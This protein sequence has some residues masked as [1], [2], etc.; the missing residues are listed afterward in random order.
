MKH[1][2]WWVTI[3][4]ILVLA[5]VCFALEAEC[6]G[7]GPLDGFPEGEATGVSEDGTVVVGHYSTEGFYWTPEDGMT[8]M[9]R[10]WPLATS[11]DGSVIVGATRDWEGF[12]WTENSDLV[13]IGDLPG[14]GFYSIARDVSDDGSVIVGE[15]KSSG[16]FQ[17]FRWTPSRGMQGL[18]DFQGGTFD[19]RGFAVSADGSPRPPRSSVRPETL[20]P[21]VCLYSFWCS[22][23]SFI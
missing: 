11:Y 16:G 13:R 8:R 20:P 7:L 4:F 23:E 5:Q 12:Y 21:V 19:S 22:S 18:G 15:S 1:K 14:G 3:L 10:C 6:H 17:A 9:G 2:S